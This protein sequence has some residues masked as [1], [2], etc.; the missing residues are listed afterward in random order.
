MQMQHLS[1]WLI[2]NISRK[3]LKLWQHV[4][5]VVS[6]GRK[7]L[8]T[9]LLLQE[10]EDVSR[11]V[12]HIEFNMSVHGATLVS[13]GWTSV[14][15][16]PII[17]FL[18]VSPD[19]AIFEHSC[20]TSGCEKNA[21]YICDMV[22]SQIADIGPEKIVQVVMDSAASCVAAGKLVSKTYP[23]IVCSPCSAHCL[24][25][26]LE[27]IGK[28]SWVADIVKQGHDV[29][30]FITNH[31]A[32]L[33]VFREHSQL[34][35]AKPCETR[36][37]T[38]FTML[39]RLQQCQSELQATVVSKKFKQCSSKPCYIS[40]SRTVT[41]TIL[42][43]QFWDTVSLAMSVCEPFVKI[44]RLA[45]GLVPCTG[46]IYWK[47]YEANEAIAINSQL[48]ANVKNDLSRIIM[49]RWTMLHTDLHAAG[50]V[51][52]PEYQQYLQHENEEVMNGFHSMIERTFPNNVAAQVKA[53]EQHATY[54]AGNHSFIAVLFNWCNC[55]V[56]ILLYI[57]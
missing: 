17:N 7:L 36:F 2:A 31:H 53:I 54:R 55:N 9:T 32:S 21:Q 41:A 38:N 44:L 40:T 6:P 37:A 11:R 24:D 12:D 34:E 52:D 19:G 28:L 42:S 22:S 14:Q 30:K 45:D 20:E 56:I 27:D 39:Q 10:K 3:L 48:S 51:L 35:L 18:L 23:A 50:F 8:S 46:K 57:S 26:L 33:A 47:I 43:Q 5:P 29:V 16:R 13:D 25:L 1:M 49:D 4:V 15:N